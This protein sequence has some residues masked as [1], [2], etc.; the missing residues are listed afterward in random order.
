MKKLFYILVL[1]LL[2]SSVYAA[3]FIGS[4]T[5][6]ETEKSQLESF[7]EFLKNLP[8]V[9][10]FVIQATFGINGPPV[11]YTIPNQETSKNTP[12]TLNLSNYFADPNINDKLTYSQIFSYPNLVLEFNQTNQSVKLIPQFNFIGT[13]GYI[14]IRVTD[15]S[16]TFCDS[17]PFNLTVKD[18][19]VPES[20]P[21]SPT[22]QT[23][24]GGGSG[25]GG[26]TQR[27]PNFVLDK[28][29]IEV[30]LLPLE[31]I[32]QTVRVTNIGDTRLEIKLL[33]EFPGFIE[34]IT[35]DMFLV[36][37]ETKPASFII[38]APDLEP[39]VYA[40]KIKFI[41]EGITRII[42]ILVTILESG[43]EIILEVIVPDE[44]KR[45]NPGNIVKAEIITTT[46]ESQT[47]LNIQYE[48]RDIDGKPLIAETDTISLTAFSTRIEKELQTK[49]NFEPGFYQFYVKINNGIKDFSASDVFEITLEP[50]KQT[51]GFL[52]TRNLLVGG[53][54][55]LLL[56]LLLS[57][58]A[59]IKS[60]TYKDIKKKLSAAPKPKHV[61]LT[62]EDLRLITIKKL[63][64]LSQSLDR[65]DY[66]KR[67]LL[68]INE[69]IRIY[70]NIRFR[71]TTN[72]AIEI[73]K[74]KQT[75]KDLIALLDQIGYLFYMKQQPS[76]KQIYE[77]IIETIKILNRVKPQSPLK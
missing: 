56:I 23:G 38:M 5:V 76:E 43:A 37:K 35:T 59:F 68:V 53:S 45:V 50:V 66:V 47:N 58:Y 30:E 2:I 46:E 32:E 44:Y 8:I 39:D 15:Q 24:G 77:I 18:T 21:P 71:F 73:L 22:I 19:I 11:C 14:V 48:I 9:G 1:I 25:G 42:N 72:E 6:K 12:L 33:N 74:K 55:I 20:P 28:N 4:F 27:F 70:Y 64:I 34:L 65:G 36:L 26:T 75:N 63:Q 7:K 62:S 61:S 17:N 29:V 41:S 52:S 49:E 51:P 40:G 60:K 13:I 31:S 69:F 3:K 16:G 54:I 67:Y 57:I 10:N